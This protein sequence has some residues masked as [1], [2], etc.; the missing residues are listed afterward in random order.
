MYRAE[1]KE[2]S[3]ETPKF[4]L[5]C[6]VDT[7]THQGRDAVG[8]G[9]SLILDLNL[10][11]GEPGRS[12]RRSGDLPPPVHPPTNTITR[13]RAHVLSVPEVMS[14]VTSTMQTWPFS[15]DFHES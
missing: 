13:R 11:F 4:Q 15:T 7:A 2:A 12:S 5:E 6:W 1:T 10:E 9:E 14:S 8:L 3:G